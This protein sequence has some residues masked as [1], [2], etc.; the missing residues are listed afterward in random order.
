MRMCHFQHSLN[1]LKTGNL[2]VINRRPYFS[3][4]LADFLQR[5]SFS[6]AVLRSVSYIHGTH[7]KQR[8]NP[9][10]FPF[11]SGNHTGMPVVTLPFKTAAEA[12]SRGWKTKGENEDTSARRPLSGASAYR[13]C[14]GPA[15][16]RRGHRPHRRR[17]TASQWLTGRHRP[18]PRQPRE[19]SRR[20]SAPTP[21]SGRGPRALRAAG[22]LCCRTGTDGAEGR[23]DKLLTS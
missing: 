5:G 2:H 6:F 17:R 8:C 14:P 23:E 13:R 9:G 18:L 4:V 15:L 22:F 12:R 3:C 7:R 11:K 21:R 20:A 16:S 10:R 1:E 19:A